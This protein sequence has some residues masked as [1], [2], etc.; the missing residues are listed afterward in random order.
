MSSNGIKRESRYIGSVE[1]RSMDG[2]RRIGGMGVPYNTRSRLLPGGFFEVVEPSAVRK[3]LA[4]KLNIVSRLEHHPEWLLATTDSGT[5]RLEDAPDGLRYEADL[6]NTQAGSETH[7]LVRTNRLTGASMGF[8]AFEQEFAR[9]G[10]SLVRHLISIRLDEISPV[11]QP[12]YDSSSTSLRHYEPAYSALA[13]QFG[14]D[15]EEVFALAQKGELRSLLTRTDRQVTA[16]PTVVPTPKEENGMDTDLAQRIL[17]NHA[18]RMAID[19]DRRALD[20]LQGKPVGGGDL[21]L[22]MRLLDL[23]ER[24][25]RYD[26]E[27]IAQLERRRQQYVP[28]DPNVAW[29]QQQREILAL[30][31]QRRINDLRLAGHEE[32]VTGWGATTLHPQQELPPVVT[33]RQRVPND[34]WIS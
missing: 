6:P 13:A 5:L 28:V 1:D 14:E 31:T 32:P 17:K 3:T 19:G 10:S 26:A 20:Q 18:H 33:P 25:A 24:K 16:P 9:M 23:H 12:A 4:D 2:V 21:D 22:R 15:P 34:G 29:H 8:Q 7:E 30:A 11:S 27:E